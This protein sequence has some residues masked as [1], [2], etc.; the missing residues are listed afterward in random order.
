ML[1]IAQL[2]E[3]LCRYRT[4]EVVVTSMSSVHPWA[5]LS[6]HALDLALP[7]S[8]MDDVADLAL[9]IALARPDRDVI[10]LTGDDSG[11]GTLGSLSTILSAHAMNLTLILLDVRPLEVPGRSSV[12]PSRVNHSALAEA[13]GF[14]QVFRV[15]DA[16]EYAQSVP[17]MLSLTGPIFIHAIVQSGNNTLVTKGHTKD[18]LQLRTSLAESARGVLRALDLD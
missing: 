10:C 14:D 13:S 7:D 16:R 9:G 8:T 4:N 2:L 1:T 11:P 5:R 3:P 12:T 18:I 17:D 6:Q 15:E